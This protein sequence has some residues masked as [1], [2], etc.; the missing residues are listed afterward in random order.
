MKNG[1]HLKVEMKK[2][3]FFFG[4]IFFVFLSYQFGIWQLVANKIIS[5]RVVKYQGINQDILDNGKY[6]YFYL[7]GY[8]FRLVQTW[9]NLSSNGWSPDP[10][11]LSSPTAIAWHFKDGLSPGVIYFDPSVV[12]KDVLLKEGLLV[13]FGE[14]KDLTVKLRSVENVDYITLWKRVKTMLANDLLFVEINKNNMSLKGTYN[15]SFI[16]FYEK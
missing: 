15:I 16:D 12:K 3:L 10:R 1:F 4:A 7:N 11:T 6:S 2:P 13:Q 8:E 14:G 5:T 9:W